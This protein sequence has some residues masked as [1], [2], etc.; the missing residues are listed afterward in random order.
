MAN[1]KDSVWRVARYRNRSRLRLQTYPTVQRIGLFVSNNRAEQQREYSGKE[2]R[3][4]SLVCA[5][6]A[7]CQGGKV[8]R[9]AVALYVMYDTLRACSYDAR[10]HKAPRKKQAPA[11]EG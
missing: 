7:E 1:G 6:R 9:A 4:E 8:C 3:R 10:R 5:G 2:G 11:S